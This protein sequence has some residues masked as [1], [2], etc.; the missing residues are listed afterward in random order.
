M[1]ARASPSPYHT[2]GADCPFHRP[3]FF[4]PSILSA[5]SVVLNHDILSDYFGKIY[6][7]PIFFGSS[8]SF[9][10]RTQ[11]DQILLIRSDPVR[12]FVNPIRSGPVI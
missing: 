7:G 3:A 5:L 11:S 2:Y 4:R 10:N 9:V 12:V 6:S 8:P 1:S